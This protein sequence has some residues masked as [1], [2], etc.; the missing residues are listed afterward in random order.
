[1]KDMNL[2]AIDQLGSASEVCRS[3]FVRNTPVGG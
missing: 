2:A 3:A 1:M